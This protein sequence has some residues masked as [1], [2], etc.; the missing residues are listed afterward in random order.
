MISIFR[1]AKTVISLVWAWCCSLMSRHSWRYLFLTRVQS[2]VFH[3]YCF[4]RLLERT[5]RDDIQR[6]QRQQLKEVLL[7]AFNHV[8]YYRDILSRAHVCDGTLVDMEHFSDIPPLTKKIIRSQFDDLTSDDVN[9]RSSY[10]NYS[11]GSIGEPIRVIQDRE[12]R[13]WEASNW[14]F[15]SLGGKNIG[16]IQINMWGSERDVLHGLGWRGR[17]D[18]YIYNRVVCNTFSFKSRDMREFI[19]RWNEVRPVSVWAYVDS[20]YEWARYISDHKLHIHSPRSIVVTAGTLYPFQREYIERVFKCPV[21]NQYGSREVG[22]IAAECS[23]R[24]GLH[25]F[26]YSHYVEILDDRLQPVGEGEQGDVYVT[27]LINKSMPL[28]RYKIGDT[29][30]ATHHSCSCGRGFSLIKQ[31]TGRSSDHF[32]T[33]SSGMVHGEYFTHCMYGLSW[34][35]RFRIEQISYDLIVIYLVS[36]DNE[37]H[38]DDLKK[39]TTHIKIVMG[40]GCDVRYE[41][42][43][44]IQSTPSGKYRYTISHVT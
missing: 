17:L 8:P 14:Y 24:E 37:N 21:L 11:G 42:V 15:M 29:A 41:Y 12:Y 23:R 25:V 4:I 39:V 31:V 44:N 6:I 27:S 16:D 22:D 28:I 35:D 5:S 38:D 9:C 43:E 33:S 26:E 7:H 18:N 32:K 30:L 3:H 10:V 19:Y 20:M 34:V 13:A 40:W 36:R 2:D 1:G